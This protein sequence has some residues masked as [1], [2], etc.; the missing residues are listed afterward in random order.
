[1]S[2]TKKVLMLPGD[3]IG[4]EVMRQVQRVMDWMAKKRSVNFE[5]TEGLIGGASIDAHK[6]PLTDETLADAMAADAVLLGAVG[7]P[8]WDDM[9]FDIKPERGLLKIRKEMGLFANLRPALV[10]DALVG[11][12]TL[13]EDVVK[14]LDIMILREL[15]G[16]IYFGQP[17]G[18]EERD[19]VRHGFNTLVYSEPEVERIA[20]VAFDMAMKRNKRLCSVDKANVLESTVLWREVVER[21]AKDFPEVE[22][23]HMYVDNAA[24]QL[25]RNPKQFDVMVTT[26]M[27]GDILSDCAAMLTGSLGMLPSASL[28]AA[29]ANG[30]RK[31]LYEPVHGSAPD[32]A[33]QD[34]A[35]PLATI[36]SF[37]MMLRYSF[38]M[39]DDATLIE[40]AVQNVLKGG[41]RTADIMQPGMAKVSTTVMGESL[42]SELDKLV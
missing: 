39:G 6:N 1:M 33:G 22:L 30:A 26:N 37:A 7:G 9:P 32:I 3:G 31:A 27:F 18:I 10:F 4:P 29:D 36:L 28:G 21:V 15:T 14:G 11:A 25:V 5:I 40:D 20:R 42:I 23:S 17:R 38:D 8:K 41:L 13:K 34:I 19:G 16:G 2:T 12:S 35:N 24:M